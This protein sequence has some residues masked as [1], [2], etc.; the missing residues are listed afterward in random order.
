MNAMDPQIPAPSIHVAMASHAFDERLSAH[1][2]SLGRPRGRRLPWTLQL[3]VAIALAGGAGA[4]GY[5]AGGDPVNTPRAVE[6]PLSPP[7]ESPHLA[8]LPDKVDEQVGVFSEVSEVFDQQAGWVAFANGRSEM[9]MGHGSVADTPHLLLLRLSLA[10]AGQLVSRTD[11]QS[12]L[13]A[14]FAAAGVPH[15]RVDHAS[16]LQLE[17]PQLVLV[18]AGCSTS[19]TAF[20]PRPIGCLR[21]PA[22]AQRQVRVRLPGHL[23]PR[24]RSAAR[25]RRVRGSLGR[26]A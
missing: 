22:K 8:Y 10:R 13:L 2:R 19:H 18:T 9:G 16:A 7:H 3:A 26:A 12:P 4:V 6:Q 24:E 21:R 20:R 17:P 11:E 1:A 25:T 14:A 5:Q 15:R 23:Q